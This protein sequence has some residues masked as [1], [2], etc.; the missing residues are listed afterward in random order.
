MN[1]WTRRAIVLTLLATTAGLQA[2]PKARHLQVAV[3]YY[4]APDFVRGAYAHWYAPQAARFAAEAAALRQG[5]DR[6]CSAAGTRDEVRQRW[7]SAVRE[8]EKLSAVAVGP[9][10]QRRSTRQ[11]DFMPARP[12][13]IERAIAQAP[14]D[15]AG[16]ERIGT[17]AKGFP[18]LEWLLWTRP[19]AP[20]SDGCRYAS[21]LGREID[22]EAKT[23]AA[24]FA[25]AAAR[26]WKADEAGTTAAMAEIVN[27]WIG[28]LERLR[29]AQMEKPLRA[30]RSAGDA[31]P[32]YPRN[33]AASTAPSWAAQWEALRALGSWNA[34]AAPAPGSGLV[35]LEL[36]LRG[37]GLNPLA[38]RL[39]AAATQA[40]SRVAAAR[41]ASAASVQ[42]ASAALARVKRVA[43]AQ[44]AP[45][46]EVQVGFSDSDGD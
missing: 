44:V 37:R 1:G 34:A 5:L 38:D 3:P 32:A 46:L 24:A 31:A 43:V 11:I 28:G 12:P 40:G 4:T 22:A 27:Q 7:T 14:E 2:A 39:A 25:A 33:A 35:P 42:A 36:Y 13:L 10:L 26:D 18:A 9:L 17:P 45:A 15:L 8:W 6:F 41:P 21:L 20:G 29:W 30:A 19:V 23:L 16:L